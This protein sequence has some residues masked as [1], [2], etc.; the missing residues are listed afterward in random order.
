MEH[1]KLRE[2][3]ENSQSAEIRRQHQNAYD[4]GVATPLDYDKNGNITRLQ[5]GTGNA[6][7]MNK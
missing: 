5:R 6:A 2:K 1:A 4:A 3:D 7:T